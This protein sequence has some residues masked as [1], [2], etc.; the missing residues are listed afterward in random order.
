MNLKSPS[1][2]LFASVLLALP[3]SIASAQAAAPPAWPQANVD[4]PADPNVRFGVLPNGMRYAIQRNQTPPGQ[5]ALRMWV[6]AGSLMETDAQQGLAHYLEHMAFNGSKHVPEGEMVKIL[7][8]HGLAFGADTNAQTSWNQTLY[9]LDL[10]SNDDD[11]LDTGLKLLRET[12]GELLLDPGAID[13]ER[14]VILSEERTRDTPGLHVFKQG[15]AFFL[16]DQLASR[17]LP[18]G[19]VAIIKSAD[20]A[21]IGDF[22]RKYY[23]PERVVL[24]VVGDFDVDAMEARIKARFSDWAAQGPAGAEPVLGQPEPRQAETRLVIEPGS[25]LSIQLEWLNPPDLSPDSQAKRRRKLIEQLGLAVLNRRLDHLA[26]SDTPPFIGAQASKDDTFHSAESTTIAVSAQPAQWRPALTAADQE[27]RRIVQYGVRPDELAREVSEYRVQYQAAVAQAA[28]RK[29]TQI[30]EDIVGTLPDRDVYTAPAEDLALFEDVAKGLT[31]DEVSQA[32]KGVF[33]G[34]GPLL[35][36]ASPEPV[37]GGEPALTQAYAQAEATPVTAPTLDAA[38]TWPYGDFGPPGKVA[39]QTEAKD[40]GVTF[41][42]FANGVVLTVKPTRFRDDQVL[43][44][45][46]IGH[47]LLDLPRDRVTTAWASSGA[48]TDGGLKA[49]TAQEVERILAANI[50]GA[51]FSPGEDAFVLQGSTRPVDLNVQLQVLAAY[52]AEPGFRPEAFARMRTYMGTL[53]DQLEATPSGV[54][55]LHLSQLMH[56]GDDRFAFPTPAQVSAGTPDQFQA[57][58]KPRV[59]TGPIEVVI[60]GDITLDK[61]IALTAATFGALPARAASMAA[62]AARTVTLPTPSVQPVV[63]THKGRADQAVGYAEW[64]TDDFFASPQQAR[65]LRVLAQI[66]ENRLLEDLREKA[67]DTYSPQAGANASLVFPHYGYVSAVVEIPPAKI[68]EFYADL[69]KISADLRAH[70]VSADE[71]ER[72][73]KPLID[74]LQK[75][76]QLNEYWLEQLSGAQAEPRKINAVRTVQQSLALVTPAD[77]QAAAGRYLKDDRLWKLQITPQGDAATASPTAAKAP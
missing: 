43:V 51:E 48:F 32:L 30:A 23:R 39:L 7:E 36:M 52:A 55:S 28:T 75:Q 47:G 54:M 9:Q 25:S 22:Y 29:T 70:P 24:T 68:G 20:Q 63:L 64:P 2:A 67:G 13:R 74:T 19:Q 40:L 34:Q 76:R 77:L 18:I 15:L 62:P 16:K 14:G 37:A 10:P 71:L 35:F 59:T 50:Y 45:A 42:R 38:K 41:V 46:R 21:L 53:H 17:R 56:G 3:P 8:R 65:T 31:A 11:T 27:E 66:V 73:R 26:R 12:A 72:A 57:L 1:A 4:I 49:L 69:I 33:S 6:N 58:L 60:V 5:A 61:A 44:R